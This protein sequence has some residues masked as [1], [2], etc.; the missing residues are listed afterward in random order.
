MKFKN[1]KVLGE[2]I[3]KA[4]EER[5]KAKR[6]LLVCAGTGCVANGSLEVAKEFEKGL[7]DK[8][9]KVGLDILFKKTGCHG[10]CEKGPIVTFQPE[11]IFYHRV[12]VNDVPEIIEKTVLKGEVV[13]R[14]LYQDPSTKQKTVKYFDIPFYAK[15]K[16]VVLK[17]C[18][19]ID[20][21]EIDEY[22]SVGGYKALKKVLEEKD[23]EGIID[24]IEDSGLR[25]RGG[26][27]FITGKKWRIC[28]EAKGDKKYVICNGDEGD[29]G[30]F[31]DRSIMEGNPHGI[32][33]GMIIG[34]YAVGAD[35]GIIY[36]RHEYPLAVEHLTKAIE[37]A[38]R[39]GLLGEKILGTDFSFDIRIS[40]GG[41]AF[42]CGEETALLLSV[43]GEP[44]EPR[45]RPPYPAVEGLWGK[46]TVINNVET[47]AN[48]PP[49][50]NNG[51]KW[52]KDLG[53]KGSR[54]TKVFSLVGKVKNTGLVEVPMGATLRDIIFGIGGG[55][56]GD[57]PFKAVQTGGPSGGC[58]PASKLD[59]PIDYETLTEN[60]SM[61]GSGGMIVM[62]DKTCMVD[63]AKY[64]IK[65]L[66]GESCGKCVPCRE[67]LRQLSYILD[68]IT[69]GRGKEGDVERMEELSKG[70]QIGSLCALGQTAPNP[71]LSTIK[72]FRD[73][74]ETH[75]REKR[76]PAGVCKALIRYEI[77]E[78]CTGCTVCAAVCPV[79]AISGEKKKRHVIDYSKCTKC[80]ACFLSCRF[81]AIEVK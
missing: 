1:T 77:N 45:P 29:P 40:R 17:N 9:V 50:I 75:I 20:P 79:Q 23:P 62:D 6:R 25:G 48:V 7:A 61:M 38:R 16:R 47:F 35:E 3:K 73:E 67:G 19:Q 36:V 33:E 60:G 12:S 71:V 28:R 53:Y 81:G 24:I 34:A 32:I 22:F 43:M 76:C 64:F 52:F 42:V 27:G 2:Y 69:E 41:G 78:K 44:G 65:F 31:M 68:D 59:L 21:S 30:A 57:R 54:G 5:A 26:G 70:I 13:E 11:G 14:L 55:I 8:G 66:V 18:G 56:L 39:C 15:Q 74:Y 63:V 37:A 80:G 51:A 58:L 46:P 10:F 49:I 72:Y 4:E